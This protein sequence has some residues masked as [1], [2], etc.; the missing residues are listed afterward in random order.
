MLTNIKIR[1]FKKFEEIEFELGQSVVLIGPNNSGKTSALQALALWEIGLKKWNIKRK[2]IARPEKRPGVTIIRKDILSI[3]TPSALMLWKNMHVRNIKKIKGK[4]DTKN[5]RIDIIVSGITKGSIWECGLEFDYDNEESLYV[6]PLRISDEHKSERMILP[7]SAFNVKIAYLPPMSGLVA[8]EAKLEPGRI[9]VLLGEGQTA[10]VL[11]NLC[12]VIYEK[13]PDKDW[14]K[15]TEHIKSLFGVELQPP[16][17][18]IERGEITMY[19]KERE[20]SLLDLSSSGRGLQQTLLLLTHLYANPNTVLL[21]DEPD[22]HLEVLRQRQIF[23][24]L[25]EVA[26]EKGSQII[27]ASHSEVVLN[28]AADR[29]IVIAF[30]GKP[31]RIDGRSSQAQLLKSLKDIGFDQFVQAE[32]RGWVLYI[33]GPSDLAILRGLAKKLDH[34]AYNYLDSPFVHYVSTNIPEKAREHFFGLKEAKQDLVGIAIFDHIDRQLQGNTALIETMWNRREIENYIIDESVLIQYARSD[35]E[36]DLFGNA[37]ANQREIIMKESI[38]EV[39]SAIKTLKG[40]ERWSNEV[41][42]SDE[43]LSPVFKKY[44]EKLKLPNIMSKSNYFRLIEYIEKQ[45]IDQEIIDKLD[46]I[47]KVSQSANPL[48]SE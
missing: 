14:E 48:D 20:G 18:L 37:E 28:E 22:A 2:S 21:L 17:Y 19:Y 6:R 35:Q 16:E 24:M 1:N 5:V 30:I 15:I 31:H 39:W 29:D 33:E 32:E 44:Y 7:Q 47:L 13:S 46:T 38:D 3:P 11:R 40:Y 9:N 36:D 26:K 43:F 4:L 10:Q 41:K 42:A 8:T 27:S 25:T 45:N 12:Y 34:P 23:N